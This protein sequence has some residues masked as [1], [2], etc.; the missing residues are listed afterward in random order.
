MQND[1]IGDQIDLAIDRGID[2]L[3]EHQL[4]NGEF[5]FYYSP[6][7]AMQEWCVPDSTVFPASLIVSCL[8]PFK[9]T[10]RGGRICT[11]AARFLTYQMMRGG[12]WNYFTKWNPLF[13][14]S[15][16]DTDDTA[17]AS[18]VLRSL[19]IDF[20]D[21]KEV[22]LANRNSRGL[23]YT[24]FI[25][26]RL[27]HL[28]GKNRWTHLRE[29]KYPVKSLLFWFRNEAERSD[30]DPVVNANILFYLG[31]SEDTKAVVELLLETLEAE[32][33]ST[34]DKWYRN[35]LFFYYFVSRNYPR[36]NALEPVRD[37]IV[38]RV[39]NHCHPDGRIGDSVLSTALALSALLN[40]GGRDDRMEQAARYLLKTQSKTGYW[41][42]SIYYYSG[43]SKMIGW[44]SEELTTAQCI[45]ALY[46]YKTAMQ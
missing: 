39:Y 9:D 19:N 30:V 16:A 26:R 40:F 43:P 7:D 8:L 12:V 11:A 20:P 3:Y 10:D 27:N 4:P 31:L 36:I 13:K 1:N 46:K 28:T 35:P 5:A 38:N 2:F 23:F 42:R 32:K 44:G 45:E 22:L 17:Y 33:E 25:T 41:D 34:A 24:W 14:Y 15:P 37:L 21:N 18:Y 6:D 29:F